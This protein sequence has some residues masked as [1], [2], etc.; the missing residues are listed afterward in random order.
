MLGLTPLLL[1][2]TYY[3]MRTIQQKER[4]FQ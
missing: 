1:A 2:T 3:N 4:K